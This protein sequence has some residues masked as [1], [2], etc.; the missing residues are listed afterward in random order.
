MGFWSKVTKSVT[1]IFKNP[2]QIVTIAAA[3]S[4]GNWWYVAAAVSTST[5]GN[6]QTIRAAEKARDAYNASLKDRTANALTTEEPFQV[7]YGQARVGGAI[8]AVL[9]SGNKDQYRHIVLVHAA[10]EV[11]EI[12]EI[13]VNNIA[14]GT[15]DA[16]GNVTSGKY[17]KG[18]N[19]TTNQSF[20]VD[21]QTYTLSA[22]PKEGTVTAYIAAYE[23]TIA[24]TSVVGNVVTLDADVLN[25]IGQSVQITYTSSTS[26]T[27]YVRV[28]KHLGGATDPA[29]ASLISECS[30]KWT[31][32][33]LLRGFAYTVVR[34]DLNF[35]DFQSGLPQINALIKGKKLYDPRTSTTAWSDNPAL[36]IYDYLTADYG[37][38]QPTTSIVTSTF[39][40]AADACDEIIT[41]GKRFTCNGSFKTDQDPAQVLDTLAD[42]MAGFI[43]H[44]GGWVINAGVYTEPVMSLTEDDLVGGVSISPAA[45]LK[46]TFNTVTGQ[47]ANPDKDYVVTDYQPYKNSTFLAEDGEELNIDYD[48]LFTNSN[49]RCQNITRIVTERARQG[50][51]IRMPCTLKAWPLQCGDRVTVTNSAYGWTNKVFRVVEWSF[52]INSAVELILQEDGAAIYDEADEVNS[53]AFP[54]T[55]LGDLYVINAPTSLN[56]ST[57][58]TLSSDGTSITGLYVTWTAPT[59]GL[60]T[61]YEVQW[62]ASGTAPLNETNYSVGFSSTTSYTITPIIS[63]QNYYV[64]VR[65]INAQGAKSG[66]VYFNLATSGDSVAPGVPTSV[67][68]TAAKQAIVI[69]WTNPTDTDLNSVEIWSN[70]SATLVGISKVAETKSGRYTHD[71]LGSNATRYYYLRSKDYS[72][73]LSTWT[74]VVSATTNYNLADQIADDILTTAAFAQG[75][76]PVEIVDTLPSSGNFEGRMAYLTTDNKLY[77]YTGSAWSKAVDAP[78]IT[79]EITGT[80]IANDSISTPKLQANSI[81]ADKIASNAVTADKIAANSISAGKIQAGAIGADQI[82]ANAVS[83]DKIAVSSLSAINANLGTVTAGNLRANNFYIGTSSTYNTCKFKDNKSGYTLNSTA[84]SVWDGTNTIIEQDTQTEVLSDIGFYI[85]GTDFHGNSLIQ[86]AQRVRNTDEAILLPTTVLFTAKVDHYLSLW[87]RYY[88]S[89]NTYGSWNH[90]T[91]VTEQAAS[92]GTVS[93]TWASEGFAIGNDA[94]VQFGV[95]ATNADYQW[96]NSGAKQIRD[97]Y[98]VILVSNV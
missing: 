19:T 86:Q 46:D 5:Y 54:N 33:H 97:F 3:I 98:G 49:Q 68:A 56:A 35:E 22:T 53:D 16:N 57:T 76:V 87:W 59:N 63:G 36:C 23:A 40:T 83:A 69:T 89:N 31:S 64:R 17:F 27:S 60:A 7:I 62:V 1:N 90:C 13:Y 20:T 9:K 34:I 42:S 67:T 6:Y 14:L 43:T 12:G 24:V 93:I 50:M 94:A 15:L 96:F 81:S 58:T 92:Y 45:S 61:Q 21:D 71:N 70:T 10:H 32:A 73:N 28:K 77:R 38:G 55:G 25:Y 47:F 2:A 65:S 29:D 80:Q 30:D 84:L 74:S 51:T 37:R 4:T 26:G 72:G 79:G 91:T 44:S 75:I 11:E 88:F 8:A 78:D 41:V 85:V 39:E 52:N 48:L 82:A 18:T 66:W 95:T